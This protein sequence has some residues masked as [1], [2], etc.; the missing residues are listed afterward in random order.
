MVLMVP[1]DITTTLASYLPTL[2]VER[3]ATDSAAGR[4]PIADHRQGSV[5]IADVSGFTTITERLAERGAA[6]AEELTRVINEYFGHVIDIILAHGGDIVRFAGDAVLAVWPVSDDIDERETARRSTQCGLSLQRELASYRSNGGTQL[7]MKIGVGTGDFTCM[8]LGGEFHRWEVLITGLAFVQSFSALEHAKAGQV[9]VSLQ[10]W[11]H[12]ENDFRAT[13]LQMGSMLVD[14]GHGHEPPRPAPAASFTETMRDGMSRYVPATVTARLAVNQENWIGEL[15]MVTV[16]FVNLPELN[17]ATPLDRAQTIV[18]YLQ[19]EL[20]RFE[21][22]IN[23]LNLDDKGTSLLAALGLPPLAHEDDP[24][25]GV[26]AAIAIRTRLL[27]LGLQSSI[28]IAT[29]R[30]YCGSVGSSRR[31]EYTL[32]G[33]VVNLAARLM[34]TALGDIHCDG[35]TQRAAEKYVNFQRLADIHVKGKSVPVETFRPIERRD[36]VLT[37]HRELVGREHE[38]ELFRTS[39]QALAARASGNRAGDESAKTTC[40]V[41]EGQAGIGK[42]SL[43]SELLHQAQQIGVTCYVGGGD[44]IESTTLYYAWR[45]IA[46]QLLGLTAA[47]RKASSQR[48]R[49]LDQLHKLLPEL[50][51]LAPLLAEAI[52]IEVPDNDLTR[53]MTGK[54]RGD[55]TREVLQKLIEQGTK[56]DPSLI[57]IEDTHWLDSASWMLLNQVARDCTSVLLVLTSRPV[58]GD[59]QIYRDI[60]ELPTTSYVRLDRLTLPDTQQMLCRALGAQDL[61]TRL[62]EAV[63]AKAAG[64]PLFTDQ[65][66]AVVKD[67]FRSHV[68]NA[69]FRFDEVSIRN[70][71]FPGTLHGAITARIDNLQPSP[72]LALKVASVIG[73]HFG[74]DILHDNYPVVSERNRLHESLGAILNSSLIEVDVSE[75]PVSYQFQHA[76]TRQV[77][78][79]LLLFEQRQRLHKSIAEWYESSGQQE[80]AAIKP[81]LAYHWQL[82]GFHDRAIEYLQQA[83]DSALRNGAYSEAANFFRQTIDANEMAG[84]KA[85]NFARAEWHRKLAEAQLGLGQLADSQQA[86]EKALQLLGLAIPATSSRLVTNLSRQAIVQLGHLLRRRIS[87]SFKVSD[88]RAATALEAARCYERLTEIYYLSNDRS[89]LV[90]AISS[91]LNLAERAGP[92][93]ELARAYA[94]SCFAIGLGGLHPL[95]R[96]YAAYA[97]DAGDKV[98]DPSASAWVLEATG[99][100][101]LAMGNC[102]EAQS[103]FEPAIELWNRIGDWQHWGETMAL[104]A[105]AA[106]F[107]GDFRRGF[108][109]WSGLYERADARGDDLQKAWGLNGRAEGFLRLARDNHADHAAAALDESIRLLNQNVDRVSQFG[110]YGLMALTQWRLGNLNAAR[111]AADVGLQFAQQFGSP[112]G[113]YLFNGYYGVARTYLAL[114][115][116]SLGKNDLEMSKLAKLACQNLRRYARTFPVG[117]ACYL[118]CR[119]LACW[120]GAK[121]G[122][123]LAIWRK[124]VVVAERL[125]LPFAEG[126][127]HFELARHLPSQNAQRQNHVDAAWHRFKSLDAGYDLAATYSMSPNT[128]SQAFD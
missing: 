19:Q 52:S 93:P 48:E 87:K 62:G 54:V 83:G 57:V 40:I 99:V 67:K 116:Q 127:L 115:E 5:L 15:R 45:S 1:P 60:C 76:I 35:T 125:K 26:Q 33:D 123:A 71:D 41:I 77:A 11:T 51:P 81:L 16:L 84:D 91:A 39:L 36:A 124:G 37:G 111:Q 105:Q 126:L 128:Q 42:S 78:Y 119:G 69:A 25:R 49:F 118:Q 106:Y 46:N 68:E 75:M 89:R 47:S 86:L 90:H 13:P 55:N 74:Y 113:Y 63:Y 7:S 9:V 110:A 20:Y 85:S 103:R 96:A 104:S 22:S 79:D 80:T 44:A 2:V 53:Y 65:L 114:W 88:N 10:C 34:Q 70:L 43:I 82:A 23:K 14:G 30:V 100:Y 61:P 66:I 28:G 92:T 4:D 120:L 3:L 121:H 32:M 59:A 31:R 98:G 101:H 108:E 122:R 8:H 56:N 95:A 112:T 27:E 29:G 73:H 50:Q 21:G 102:D 24:R 117:R 12:V 58:N 17:Y 97:K 72:Q 18:R 38:R 109:T 64:N 107:R 94:N 6:G